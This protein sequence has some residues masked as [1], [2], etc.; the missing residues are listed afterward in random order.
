[1]PDSSVPKA[2]FPDEVALALCIYGADLEPGEITRT[3]EVEPTHAHRKGERK[4]LRSPPWDRGAWI[5]EI[6]SFE[7]INPNNMIWELLEGMNCD[8]KVWRDLA[9]RFELR[10]D[11][12]LHTDV[13]AT[14]VLSPSSVQRIANLGAAFQIYIQAYGDNDA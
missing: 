1:M 11:F 9:S 6:R 3:L 7:P 13:G 14:F 10:F 5:R 4:T 8:P 12:A 2:Y